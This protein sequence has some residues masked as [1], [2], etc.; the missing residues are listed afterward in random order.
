MHSGF[1]PTSLTYITVKEHSKSI[2]MNR[3]KQLQGTTCFK[4][5]EPNLV[6]SYQETTECVF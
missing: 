3:F 6:G 1:V 5:L 2:S 4:A